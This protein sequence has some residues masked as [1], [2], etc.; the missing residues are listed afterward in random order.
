MTGRFLMLAF[1]VCTAS[2]ALA[3][4]LQL[5]N[6]DRISGRVVSLAAGTLTF[7]TDHG[8]LR[9]PWSSVTAL[10]V[11]QPILATV[12]GGTPAAVTIA[13]GQAPQRVT[14][15][16]GGA[17]ALETIT[18]L[19]RPEPPVVVDGTANAGFVS[20]AGNTDV[21][22]LRL[23][24]DIMT[25]AGANRF[26]I[27]AAVTRAEDSDVETARNWSGTFKYDRFLSP[28]LFMNANAIFTNDQFRDLD[29]RTA[30]G[31]GLGYQIL[32]TTIATL[33][34]DAGIG[35]VREN[36]E[37]QPDD[38]YTAARE[39]A[40]L[41]VT[42]IPDRLELFHQ[43]DIYAGVTGDDNL[44]VRMQNGVRLGVTAGFV[45]TLRL[46]SDYDRSP[47]PGLRD[48]DQTVSLTLGYRF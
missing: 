46:D 48:V 4:E 33:K 39:S 45:T 10:T 20:S 31:A 34:A 13:R 32:Q 3:D 40:A 24:G 25:R 26:T 18:A 27:S 5:A 30:L 23:D 2:P 43:H 22:S 37:L 1:F 6:G 17:V 8:D 42:A 12:S 21:N 29:L 9:I 36:L 41:T 19:A 16:P 47:A 15:T 44:F 14:L 35:W 11:D 28:R 38:R 7:A